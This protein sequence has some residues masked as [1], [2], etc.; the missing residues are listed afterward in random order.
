MFQSQAGVH[1]LPIQGDYPCYIDINHEH[2]YC[3]V[4]NY[5]S[6]NVSI[7]PLDG[8][9]RPLEPVC[10]LYIEGEGANVESENAPHAH[11]A[12]FLQ[13]SN[14]L[15]MVDLG[16]DRIHFFDIKAKHEFSLKQSIMLPAGCGPRHIVFN[17]A[18]D[19]AYVVCELSETLVYLRLNHGIWIVESELALLPREPNQSAAGAIHI[20]PNQEYV[21]ISCRVQN[22]IAIFDIKQPKPKWVAALTIAEDFVRD[23]HFTQDGRYMLVAG[24]HSHSISSYRI[25]HQGAG[26][27]P[28]GFSYQIG[29]PVC[30]QPAFN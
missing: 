25:T 11:Q 26:F 1:L 5:G 4:A 24:Q 12:L 2:T 6:G 30:L 19:S 13:K 16:S 7:Y 18:E 27:E 3:A 29:S 14:Q 10:E 23:F 28:T 15:V 8:E 21:Y 22:K 17:Q 20:I 9:G